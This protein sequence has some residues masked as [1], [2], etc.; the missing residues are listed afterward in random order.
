[1]VQDHIYCR[2]KHRIINECLFHGVYFR[3]PIFKRF[4]RSLFTRFLYYATCFRIRI[5]GIKTIAIIS[6]PSLQRRGFLYRDV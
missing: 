1:M 4:V 6:L 5:S 3:D 2:R